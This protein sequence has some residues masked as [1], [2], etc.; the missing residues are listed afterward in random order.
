MLQIDTSNVN[1]FGRKASSLVFDSYD[2]GRDSKE[3]LTQVRKMAD[4]YKEMKS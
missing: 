3:R 1:E 2:G 4:L